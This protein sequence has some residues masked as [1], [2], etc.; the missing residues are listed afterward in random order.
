[1]RAELSTGRKY[2]ATDDELRAALLSV[3]FYLNG[4]PRQ[5]ALALIIRGGC[6]HGPGLG[7]GDLHLRP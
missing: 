6:R 1:V 3:P 4:R 7:F 2:Y 5:R